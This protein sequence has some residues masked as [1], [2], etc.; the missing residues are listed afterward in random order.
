VIWLAVFISAASLDFLT[1][2]WYKAA[3]AKKAAKAGALSAMIGGLGT[4]AVFS[5]VHDPLLIVADLAGS[6][7]GS[8]YG[9]KNG[10]QDSDD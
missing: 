1:T 4:F 8:Y 10:E 9:V 2:L 3:N 5:V 6:F 7:V